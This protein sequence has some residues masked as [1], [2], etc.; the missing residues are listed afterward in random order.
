[1]AVAIR[2][3]QLSIAA[4]IPCG[5]VATML[6]AYGMHPNVF[7]VGSPSPINGRLSGLPWLCS[8]ACVRANSPSP[9][10]NTRDSIFDDTSTAVAP[11]QPLRAVHAVVDTPMHLSKAA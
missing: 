8:L 4:S 1:M 6:A 9:G 2:F 11:A 7:V 5:Y 3:H 10:V